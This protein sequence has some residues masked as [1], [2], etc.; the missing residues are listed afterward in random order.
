MVCY[1]RYVGVKKVSTEF[2]GFAETLS[3]SVYLK[4]FAAEFQIPNPNSD[5]FSF[6]L[7]VI[8]NG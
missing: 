3:G 7:L 8:V 6:A 2:L 4:T 5:V 1:E